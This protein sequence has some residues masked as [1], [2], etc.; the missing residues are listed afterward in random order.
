MPLALS[1]SL[2]Q[3]MAMAGLL[4]SGCWLRSPHFG[5]VSCCWIAEQSKRAVKDT[6]LVSTRDEEESI[7]RFAAFFGVDPILFWS[8]IGGNGTLG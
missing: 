4:R 8:E 7:T 5:Q 1:H 3:R 2:V 6:T